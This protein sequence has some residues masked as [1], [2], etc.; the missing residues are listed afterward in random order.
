MQ[1][2]VGSFTDRVYDPS[3]L[4]WMLLVKQQSKNTDGPQHRNKPLAPP[5]CLHTTSYAMHMLLSL[6][7]THTCPSN[8]NSS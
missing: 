8:D 6:C 3:H 1:E 2:N 5:I 7:Y 4:C